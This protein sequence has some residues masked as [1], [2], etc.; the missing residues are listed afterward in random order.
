MH[1]YFAFAF[2]LILFAAC[3]YLLC[4]VF[5]SI[6]PG[7]EKKLKLMGPLALL[8][9]GTLNKSGYLYLLSLAVCA[10]L[11]LLMFASFPEA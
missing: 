10:V 8:W 3:I 1:F 6:N 4:K 7:N 5:S 2:L 9:P 11:F